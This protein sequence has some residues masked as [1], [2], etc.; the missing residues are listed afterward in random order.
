LLTSGAVSLPD[1]VAGSAYLQAITVDG[2]GPGGFT[3]ELS[4]DLPP[5]VTFTVAGNGTPEAML[6]LMAEGAGLVA[7]ERREFA[8]SVTGAGERTAT[9]SYNLR[10]VAPPPVIE[11]DTIELKAGEAVDRVLASVHGDGPLTWIAP[12]ASLPEGVSLAADGT[13]SGTPTAA[14]AEANETGLFTIE[15][16]VADSHTDRVTNDPAPRTATK[17]VT[18]L[19]RLSYQLNL[20]A[21]RAGGPSF[22]QSCAGC[23]GPSSPPNV[24][25]GASGLIERASQP[26][27]LCAS[28]VYVRP[29]SPSESLL[30]RKLSAPDCGSRMPQGGP[31]MN[32]VQLGRVERWIR[33]LTELDTD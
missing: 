9:R 4:G 3:L 6:H 25:G 33:E 5:G 20:R 1:A 21:S 16:E 24:A 15:V 28:R 27:S 2:G 19:V 7:G 29:G 17:V 10:V 12:A 8:V 30:Y 11:V 32:A 14:A 31:F 18:I 13:L 22:G 26:F 23:H